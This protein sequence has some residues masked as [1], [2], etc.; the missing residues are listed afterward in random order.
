MNKIAAV[1]L[2]GEMEGMDE[3]DPKQGAT[4]LRRLF[5]A[6]G[7][8]LSGAMEEAV[9]RM[10]GGEDPDRIEEEMGDLLEEEDP[11]AASP[12]RTLA[13]LRRQYLPPRIDET[14]YDL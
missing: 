7:M 8:R 13:G 4:M 14:L 5:D 12:K 1:I 3:D 9:R 2:A 10:E 11:F 6:T